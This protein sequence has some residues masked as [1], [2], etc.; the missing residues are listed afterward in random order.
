VIRLRPRTF[1]ALREFDAGN[2]SAKSKMDASNDA[3]PGIGKA[4]WRH[5]DA[6]TQE[7]I[8]NELLRG[9]GNK[10]FRELIARLA[11]ELK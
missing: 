4:L 1:V 9:A 8:V 3:I 5:I 7:K 6:A 10:D 11:D 2:Q